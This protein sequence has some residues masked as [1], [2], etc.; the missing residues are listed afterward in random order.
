[1]KTIEILTPCQWRNHHTATR[2]KWKK[3]FSVKDFSQLR[4]RACLLQNCKTFPNNRRKH[5]REL[6]SQL[7]LAAQWEPY[8]PN[9]I[10]T[11]Y[12]IFTSES[13]IYIYIP[14]VQKCRE[15]KSWW[16]TGIANILL[17][18]TL[19]W[20]RT[21]FS[22]SNKLPLLSWQSALTKISD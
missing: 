2:Q 16:N 20:F 19:L 12:T 15:S 4:S 7:I 1:M 8:I 5:K 6:T 3:T 14:V 9:S 21:L 17:Q 22:P 13:Y 10:Y 18:N 11:L